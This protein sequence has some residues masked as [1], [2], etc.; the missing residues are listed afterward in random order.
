MRN[1]VQ[2]DNRQAVFGA[3]LRLLESA[4]TRDLVADRDGDLALARGNENIAQALSLRLMVR[5]GELA[6]LGFPDY[7]SRLH[8]LIGAPNNQRTRVTAMGHARTAVEQDPRVEQVRSVV[9]SAIEHDV[10][11]LEM[12][13]DL[14]REKTPFNLVFDL[15]LGS[16]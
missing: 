2:A 4:G 9:A 6:A 5:R 8:E 7:G 15:R 11:R 10:V 1:E 14:I 13:V 12:A 16:R 3:D